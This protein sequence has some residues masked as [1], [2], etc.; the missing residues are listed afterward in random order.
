MALEIKKKPALRG[1]IDAFMAAAAADPP[2]AVNGA[3][4]TICDVASDDGHP[5]VVSNAELT[6][7]N[8]EKLGSMT[9]QEL[10]QFLIWLQ[11][12][13][14]QFVN[15]MKLFEYVWKRYKCIISE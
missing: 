2:D 4:E 6:P 13:A 10:W 3:E 11:F 5:D 12:V 14:Y 1:I 8:L 9:S 15:F 7:F